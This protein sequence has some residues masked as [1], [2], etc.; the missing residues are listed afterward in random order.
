MQIKKKYFDKLEV[1]TWK[2]THS[3]TS[4][5]QSRA[6]AVVKVLHR[7]TNTSSLR[8]MSTSTRP[9]VSRPPLR[10]P[11]CPR[12]PRRTSAPPWPRLPRRAR[13]YTWWPRTPWWWPWITWLKLHRIQFPVEHGKMS[14]PSPLH[15]E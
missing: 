5:F 3:S 6:C 7:W 2:I 4:N 12:F 8:R 13:D 9:L 10:P 15:F 11:L 14:A 1:G